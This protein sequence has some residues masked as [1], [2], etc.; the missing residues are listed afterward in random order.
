MWQW[1]L[2][3]AACGARLRGL[4]LRATSLQEQEH[5]LSTLSRERPGPPSAPTRG[6]VLGHLQQVVGGGGADGQEVVDPADQE[7]ACR[8]H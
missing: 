1:G 4:F 7:G 3:R 8:E 2:E 6:Y 5:R